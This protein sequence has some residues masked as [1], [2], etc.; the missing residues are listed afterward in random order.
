M[1]NFM[2]IIIILD[3][4]K[5][6]KTP[7]DFVISASYSNYKS[8]S[9][10][11]LININNF[12]NNIDDKGKSILIDFEFKPLSWI[13]INFT[14]DRLDYYETYHFLKIRQLPSGINS[15]NNFIKTI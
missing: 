13:D 6:I 8:D 15:S 9:F 5:T 10:S 1:T 11:Y 12:K 4:N 3:L 7:K 14:Y 2:M